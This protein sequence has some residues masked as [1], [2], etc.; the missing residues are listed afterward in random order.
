[1]NSKVF[2]WVEDEVQVALAV[3]DEDELDRAF[4]AGVSIML[5]T[6]KV[7]DLPPPL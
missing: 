4:D 7:R 2:L 5:P 6:G 1:M 3:V